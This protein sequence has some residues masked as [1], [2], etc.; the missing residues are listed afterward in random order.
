MGAAGVASSDIMITNVVN[1][2]CSNVLLAPSPDFQNAYRI[3]AE[4]ST[5]HYLAF[6]PPTLAQM[7][8]SLDMFTVIDFVATPIE[9]SYQYQRVDEV[10]LPAV[11]ELG[12]RKNYIPLLTVCRD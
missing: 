5:G 11:V 7:T 12:G 6:D 8:T 1:N 4:S 2:A 9:Y 10:L 3:L